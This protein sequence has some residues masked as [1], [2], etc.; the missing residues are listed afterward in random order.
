[1]KRIIYYLEMIF[2]CS[3]LWVILNERITIGHIVLGGVLGLFAVL[4]SDRFLLFVNYK[5]T[6]KVRP[7]WLL[8]YLLYLLFQIYLSGFSTI[9]KIISGNINPDIVEIETEIKNDFYICILANSITLTPGTVT[10]DKVG[11]KLKVL[12]IDCT[13]KDSR[14]AGRIIKGKLEK[15]MIGR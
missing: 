7:L 15:M 3:I 6:Y 11:Q 13:T 1:M 4:I 8:K 12:W 9:S 10:V 2:L 14:L 5:R